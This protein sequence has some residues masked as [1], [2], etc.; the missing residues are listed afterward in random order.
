MRQAT[1]LFALLVPLVGACAPTNSTGTLPV[2]VL[3]VLDSAEQSLALIPVDSS[4]VARTIDL[5]PLG[6]VPRFVAARN[7]FAVVA[8]TNPA[9]QVGGVAIVDLAIGAVTQRALSLGKVT[10]VIMPEDQVAWV[11]SSSTGIVSRIDLASG[12]LD[13]IAVPGGP[14][15]LAGTRGKVFAVVGNRQACDLDPVGCGRGPSWLLQVEPGLPRDSIPLSGPGNA[16]PITTGADGNL[17]VLVPGDDFAGG[18]GR[19]DLI[20]PVR[21]IELASFARVGPVEPAWITSDGTE[22]VLFASEPGGL[23]VFNTRERRLTLPFGSGIPLTFPADLVTD[24][25]GR[26]YVLERGSCS[27]AM[28]GRIRVYRSDLIEGQPLHAGDCPVAAAIAEVPADDLFSS[29]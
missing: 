3:V 26:T 1:F 8:G 27:D 18:E 5:G 2:E 14:Q 7:Q 24:A 13:I 28:P 12:A 10:A 23:M 16:G 29:P 25:V 17:Y 11:A 15:G 6:F 19:L 20:D 4:R 22:R 21:N 9:T